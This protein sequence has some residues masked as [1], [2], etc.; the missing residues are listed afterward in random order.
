MT[1]AELKQ[2]LADADD[3]MRVV[4]IDGNSSRFYDA[5]L[6]KME[7]EIDVS[8]RNGEG[9]YLRADV[10]TRSLHRRKVLVIV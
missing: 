7:M 8:E 2:E 9:G 6:E 3:D 4:V 10:F 5:N 1:V